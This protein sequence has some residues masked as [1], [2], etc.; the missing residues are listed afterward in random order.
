[1]MMMIMMMINMHDGPKR[2]DRWRGGGG[3]RG[4]YHEVQK[5]TIL[6]AV[7]L[8]LGRRELTIHEWFPS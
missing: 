5:E 6:V 2:V 8:T 7:P 3:W 4:L 1:M